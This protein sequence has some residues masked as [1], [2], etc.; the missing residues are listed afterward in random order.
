MQSWPTQSPVERARLASAWPWE[1]D[2]ARFRNLFLRHGVRLIVNGMVLGVVVAITAG[3]YMES[4]LFGVTPTD[5]WAFAGIV[6]ILAVAAG[7]ACWLPAR[8]AANVD[9]MV[10]LRYE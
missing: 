5:P 10:A 3:Q 7:V 4:L 1:Q 6:L 8:R 9:P 2:A